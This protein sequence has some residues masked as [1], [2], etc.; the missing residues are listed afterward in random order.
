MNE[1]EETLNRAI[2]K[3]PQRNV[4]KTDDACI[5]VRSLIPLSLWRPLDADWWKK[6]EACV[7]GEDSDGH[8]LLRLCDG[9][10]RHVNSATKIDSMLSPSLRQFIAALESLDDKRR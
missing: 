8:L 10:I 2:L 9:S 7:I 3:L 4:F 6:K 1:L 5:Q